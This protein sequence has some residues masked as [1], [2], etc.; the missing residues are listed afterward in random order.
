MNITLGCPACDAEVAYE[1]VDE[2][3]EEGHA[4][5]PECGHSSPTDEWFE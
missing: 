4:K 5:C 3:E 2:S 1:D